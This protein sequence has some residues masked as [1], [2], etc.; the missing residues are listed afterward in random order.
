MILSLNENKIIN[1]EE[2]KLEIHKFGNWEIQCNG[3]LWRM[4]IFLYIRG[5]SVGRWE[6]L[7]G[8]NDKYNTFK[9]QSKKMNCPLVVKNM[10]ERE[11]SDIQR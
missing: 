8:V 3:V 2:H 7:H 9:I 10:Q 5:K 11:I 6:N 4:G 1:V